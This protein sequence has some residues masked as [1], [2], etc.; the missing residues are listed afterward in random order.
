[1]T[2]LSDTLYK[3]AMPKVKN[4]KKAKEKRL[5]TIHKELQELVACD[6]LTW[7]EK[8]EA[9]FDDANLKKEI[10]KLL[11]EL[12]IAFISKKTF[13]KEE[14][15]KEYILGLGQAIDWIN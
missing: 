7:E 1:M 4:S 6:K 9:V 12:K 8:C 11:I 15:I 2:I 5:R 14:E 13:S 10:I 3:K